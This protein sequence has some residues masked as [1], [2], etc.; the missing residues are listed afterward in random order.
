MQVDYDNTNFILQTSSIELPQWFKIQ[1]GIA[2]ILFWEPKACMQAET[3]R[4]PDVDAVFAMDRLNS[5][6]SMLRKQ[7]PVE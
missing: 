5:S 6:V 7:L 4:H 3:H 2:I 1:L